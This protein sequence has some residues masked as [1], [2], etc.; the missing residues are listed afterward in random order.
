MA[1]NGISQTMQRRKAEALRKR[2]EQE[3]Q[4]E[5]NRRYYEDATQRADALRLMELTRQRVAD[6]NKSIDG[7]V[8]VAGVS[9]EDAAKAREAN[10]KAISETMSAINAQA[11]GNKDRL[12]DNHQVFRNQMADMAVQDRLM[13]MQNTANA[14][15]NA[16]NVAG[17]IVAGGLSGSQKGGAKQ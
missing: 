15:T 4:S 9:A 7:Q 6:R 16:F 5:F 2:Q 13:R 3:E 17:S 11:S 1:I 8:A 14:L 10:N 12:L